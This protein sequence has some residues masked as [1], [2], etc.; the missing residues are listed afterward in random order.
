[1]SLTTPE[2]KALVEVAGGRVGT[3]KEC[4]YCVS[5]PSAIIPKKPQ[6]V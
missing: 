4:D 1:M 2:L 6:K 5:T 3:F